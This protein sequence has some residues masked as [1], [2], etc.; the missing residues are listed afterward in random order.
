MACQGSV[1]ST[2]ME[3][4]SRQ[5]LPADVDDLSERESL[6]FDVTNSQA[7]KAGISRLALGP[8]CSADMLLRCRHN[9][10]A[11]GHRHKASQ[12]HMHSH[13]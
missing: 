5:L 10:Y 1:K 6:L 12:Q 7:Y 11:Q 2:S 9:C 13:L 4:D 3:E 8:P